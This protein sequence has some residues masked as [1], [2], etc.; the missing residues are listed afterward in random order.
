ML[1][2]GGAWQIKMVKVPSLRKLKI[3]IV[4]SNKRA[5]FLSSGKMK[6]SMAVEGSLVL[7]I[8]LFF[9]MTVLLSLEVVRVQSNI[10][11]ALHQAGNR[12]A[13]EEYQVKYTGG[14][15]GDGEG[16]VKEYLNNQLYPYLCIKGGE[17]GILLQDL[18]TGKEN[19]QVELQAE[20]QIKSFISWLPLGD[21]KFRD[22]F[23][24]HSW[25][26]YCGNELLTDREQEI[27]VYITKTGSKYHMSHT[28]TYLR[29]QIQ[30]K[31]YEQ[32]SSLRN[33]SGGK[34]YPC[35]KCK[36]V[37]RG[38]VYVTADGKSYHSLANCSSLKRTIYMIPLS[39]A[40]TY[41]PCSK[42]GG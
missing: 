39:E 7:P 40:G 17:S 15:R 13:F 6:G 23:F 30:M 20:Y 1:S 2:L 38:N 29:V 12:M 14:E 19:G 42:C 22:R 34:Y 18:S 8:F 36:P 26:G 41:S 5:F 9:I 33:Q 21:I 35:Q 4:L 3:D 31:N 28:C 37:K 10:Q 16:Y 25:T 27:Y 32:I 11:E 24:G